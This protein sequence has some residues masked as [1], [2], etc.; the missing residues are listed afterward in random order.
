[1]VDAKC[2]N[3]DRILPIV[4]VIIRVERLGRSNQIDHY[5]PVHRSGMVPRFPDLK[6][7]AFVVHSENNKARLLSTGN[8]AHYI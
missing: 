7:V 8:R 5:A 1:M 6:K 3:V 2:G 4:C